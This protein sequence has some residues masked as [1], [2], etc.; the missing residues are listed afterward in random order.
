MR[1]SYF[2]A[3]LIVAS[4]CWGA[5]PT[6]EPIE[7]AVHDLYQSRFEASRQ[8][9]SEYLAAHP[10][11]P[12][13]YSLKAA[14][15]LFAELDSS[16]ALRANFLAADQK[17]QEAK[18][19]RLDLK[20]GAELDAAVQEARK[21]ARLALERNPADKNS[22]LAM[23]VAS[24]V[25]RDYLAMA[26]HKWR[27]SY[28]YMRESQIYAV[29]LL[30]VDPTA[31]DAYLTKGFTEYVVSSL[32]FYIRWL[33]KLDDITGTKQEGLKDLS[34]AAESGQ[35]MKPFAQLLL[36]MFYLREKQA[37]KT[38]KLLGQLAKEYPDNRTFRDEWVKA[39]AKHQ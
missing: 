22:L 25:Q 10:A 18:P 37:D 19:L 21:Y 12:L 13:A 32:P 7:A 34:I 31:Y 15:Y 1:V 16:G 11:D 39:K 29:R 26:A 28:P 5:A 14:T 23:C 3:V 9:L 33:M 20:T 17:V 8:T 6:N 38:E 2:L 30:K 24:G 27:D 36:A 35:Y 4:T